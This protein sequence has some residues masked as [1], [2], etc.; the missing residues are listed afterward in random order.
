MNNDEIGRLFK[1]NVDLNSAALGGLIELLRQLDS[2]GLVDKVALTQ[3]AAVIN[4]AIRSAESHLGLPMPGLASVRAYL[5]S[6]S[7]PG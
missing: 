7:D 2:R 6:F 5:D 1:A 3:I 4:P